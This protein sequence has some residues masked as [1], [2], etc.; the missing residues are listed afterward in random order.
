MADTACCF[1][2]GDGGPRAAKLLPNTPQL[3]GERHARPRFPV[4]ARPAGRP[5]AAAHHTSSAFTATGKEL[6]RHAI[7]P[8]NFVVIWSAVKEGYRRSSLGVLWGRSG[9]AGVAVPH[10][11]RLATDRPREDFSSLSLCR[12]HRTMKLCRKFQW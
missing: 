8:W 11:R 2:A 10:G 5:A 3:A 4:R 7:R 6:P 12:I 1:R 9:I